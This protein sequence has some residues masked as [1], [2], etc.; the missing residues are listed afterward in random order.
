MNIPLLQ[1][2]NTFG[3]FVALSFLLTNYVMVLELKRKEKE[4]LLLPSQTF[5]R[6]GYPLPVSEY[7]TNTILG[8]LFGYKLVPLFFD[9][10]LMGS[11]AQSYIFSG[12]GNWLTGVLVAALLAYLK[13]REDMKQRL[14]APEEKNILVH[15]WQH[16]GYLTLVAAVTGLIGAK[17]FHW[18]EY[19]ED[20]LKYPVENIV[21]PSGLTFFGGLICGGAGVLW[22]AKRKGINPFIMLDVGAPSMMLAYGIGRMGCHFSGDGDW[23]I[24]N[25]SPKPG[26]LSVFPDW[27][28]AYNY[29]NN[30]SQVCDPTGGG[31]PCN[32]ETT[33]YLLMPVFPTPLY[34]VLM[35]LALFGLLWFLRNK[36]KPAGALFGMYMIFAGAERFL[37]EQIRVNSTYNIFGFHPTQAELISL[38]LLAGGG[39]LIFY[40][41]RRKSGVEAAIGHNDKT[42]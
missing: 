39:A 12:Q 41:Y 21:S 15:P 1:V 35:A 13:Y 37:I 6:L 5:T 40:S 34:E 24:V 23:G 3:F 11:G 2:A 42:Q 25:T 17:V 22:A 7:V 18:L 29:P 16:M 38:L 8:F 33:P 36:I 30:V 27:I 4:G 10:S 28:W 19:W 9:S 20:F 31:M 14:P 26:W 32:F